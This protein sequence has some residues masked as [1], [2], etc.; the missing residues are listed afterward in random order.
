LNQ[1]F[2]LSQYNK[3][4]LAKKF[5]LLNRY[6]I[7]LDVERK[8]DDNKAFL[9]DLFG[10]YVEVLYDIERNKVIDAKGFVSSRILE[11][12][13]KSIDINFLLDFEK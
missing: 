4:P 5:Q 11:M 3:L 6:G 7:S 2:T 10:Y 12:Y 9:F 13:L 1:T 8:E